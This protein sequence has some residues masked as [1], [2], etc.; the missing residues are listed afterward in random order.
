MRALLLGLVDVLVRQN[1]AY[2]RA[3]PDTVALYNAGV[4]WGEPPNPTLEDAPTCVFN[5]WRD[6]PT[7]LRSARAGQRVAN[8]KDLTAWRVAELLVRGQ[9]A[10]PVLIIQPVNPRTHRQYIHVLLERPD[11]SR[12]DPSVRLGM[13]P[14]PTT[15]I[16]GGARL[17]CEESGRWTHE[18]HPDVVVIEGRTYHRTAL[19][20]PRAGVVAQYR[21]PRC[22]DTRH[23]RVYTDG[24]WRVEHID[25]HNPACSVGDA[26]RHLVTDYLGFGNEPACAGDGHGESR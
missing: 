23:L 6:I 21:E 1:V 20:A 8:C 10:R 7:I 22:R 9:A 2:L 19:A 16:V 24:I 4:R 18:G 3:H 15:P 26:A 12:E 25:A 14:M 11:G 5:E 17:C 13:D